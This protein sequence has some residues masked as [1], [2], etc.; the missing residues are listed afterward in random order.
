MIKKRLQK[1]GHLAYFVVTAALVVALPLAYAATEQVTLS[2]SPAVVSIAQGDIESIDIT[3]NSSASS[4]VT[5][6]DV[7]MTFPAN[8]VQV[9][10]VETTNSNFI[11]DGG[12]N[13][14]YNNATG[15]LRIIGTGEAVAS[16]E[17]VNVVTLNMQAKAV[18]V[19]Q[20]AIAASS[21]AGEKLSD[22]SVDNMLTD[23]KG[24]LI[25]ITVA[26][27]EPS[28]DAPPESSEADDTSSEFAA[29]TEEGSEYIPGDESEYVEDGSG[30]E[31]EAD[32]A[33]AEDGTGGVAGGGDVAAA[34]TK[35][36]GGLY[37][38]FDS[39][40]D[41]LPKI[42]IPAGASKSVAVG[43]FVI[44]GI[45]VVRRVIRRRNRGYYKASNT[46][47]ALVLFIKK[48]TGRIKPEPSSHLGTLPGTTNTIVSPPVP[49]QPSV[50][51]IQPTVITPTNIQIDSEIVG[52]YVVAPNAP[53]E[54][55]KAIKET[56]VVR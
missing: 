45:F 10:S 8:I 29:G 53:P 46:K 14:A 32:E 37:N 12:P 30:A 41:F 23:R 55:P 39:F 35:G 19:A 5:Y 40:A 6:V 48:Y 18:G 24:G 50:S 34:D 3:I 38:E 20:F 16:D 13:V 2:V 49:S 28:D 7:Q 33:F 31:G 22:G 21:Q 36:S 54:K 42:A 1:F 9:S 47:N 11:A 52:Q 43:I 27:A 26:T 17:D 51:H 15:T 44:V 25:T 4:D 56:I